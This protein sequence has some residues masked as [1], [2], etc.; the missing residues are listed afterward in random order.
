M[1]RPIYSSVSFLPFIYS[2]STAY[3]GSGHRNSSQVQTSFSNFGNSPSLS[4]QRKGTS[5]QAEDANSPH[6]PGL[7][8][9]PCQGNILIRRLNY[10]IW[11]SSTRSSS[12]EHSHHWKKTSFGCLFPQCNSSCHHSELCDKR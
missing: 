2:S 3:P 7:S 4:K 6:V 10:F 9:K 8:R 11:I 1:T 12:P 5:C